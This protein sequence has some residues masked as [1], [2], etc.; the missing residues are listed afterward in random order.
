MPP[1]SGEP[2]I[3]S[4]RALTGCGALVQS[5]AGTGGGGG[6]GPEVEVPHR[7]QPLPQTS[8]DP[9]ATEGR[10][11]SICTGDSSTTATA[12]LPPVELVS[13]TP[14][15]AQVIRSNFCQTRQVSA[16]R[17]FGLV[18]FTTCTTIR[19]YGGMK[20]LKVNFALLTLST[21]TL[22]A[23]SR[24]FLPQKVC[25]SGACANNLDLDLDTKVRVRTADRTKSS[26]HTT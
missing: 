3:S 20:Y 16:L 23:H 18:G 17:R 2:V 24:A 9:T 21:V 8:S 15:N 1:P 25:F 26:M 13:V 6:G 11:L 12:L 10:K 5:A 22:S 19:T 14:M 4:S 7:R